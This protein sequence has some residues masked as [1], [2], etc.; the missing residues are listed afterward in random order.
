[1]LVSFLGVGA[2]E[3]I[4]K[5]MVEK[6]QSKE[7]KAAIKKYLLATAKEKKAL[8][9]KLKNLAEVKRGGKAATQIQHE[10]EMK[11]EAESMYNLAKEYEELA[12]KLN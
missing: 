6:A 8:G 10:K 1:M 3:D 5:L 9:D 4:E 12:K 2:V 7:E 11:E